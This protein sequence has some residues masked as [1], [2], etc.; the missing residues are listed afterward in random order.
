MKNSGT[1]DFSKV[2]PKANK[3]RQPTIDDPSQRKAVSRVFQSD[4]D[5]MHLS[6]SAGLRVK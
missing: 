1:Q 2:D 5:L 3:T 6:R 4:D